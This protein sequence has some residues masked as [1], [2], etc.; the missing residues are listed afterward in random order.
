MIVRCVEVL[1]GFSDLMTIGKEYEVDEIEHG[2]YWIED[3][4]GEYNP[5]PQE[6]FE[7]VST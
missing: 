1:F 2:E 6:C 7:V 5:F 3:D 4:S